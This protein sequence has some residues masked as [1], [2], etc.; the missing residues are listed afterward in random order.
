MNLSTLV[1]VINPEFFS[2]IQNFKDQ[3]SFTVNKAK[4]N[5]PIPGKKIFIPG[6]RALSNRKKSLENGIILA[7][8]TL[9]SLE[10]ISKTYG[11]KFFS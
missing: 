11:I 2:G 1:Q 8:N 10:K 3:M 4:K 7:K 5:K 9:E 6:E